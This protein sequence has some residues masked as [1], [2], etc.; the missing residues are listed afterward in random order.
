MDSNYKVKTL[1]N[2]Q[3]LERM[4]KLVEISVSEEAPS[5]KQKGNLLLSCAAQIRVSL[6]SGG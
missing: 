6:N 3:N 2:D 4:H 5:V 1:L